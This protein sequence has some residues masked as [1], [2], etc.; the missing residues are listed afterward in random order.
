MI[1]CKMCKNNIPEYQVITTGNEQVTC[2]KCDKFIGFCLDGKINLY[3]ECAEFVKE[4]Y[5][6]ESVCE[7]EYE[8]LA[9]EIGGL[10]N[11]RQS[12]YGD[13]FGKSGKIL[14]VL[15]PDG[16][17]PSQYGELLAITRILDKLFRISTGH[18][19]DSYEDICGYALLGAVRNQRTKK[20]RS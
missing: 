15:Y 7:S 20:G 10:V 11:N 19:D 8:K 18:L 3:T 4:E 12:T 1:F 13:S 16:I 14:E 2:P 17:N 6:I 9:S 5:S